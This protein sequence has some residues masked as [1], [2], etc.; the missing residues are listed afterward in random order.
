[1]VLRLKTRESRSLPGLLKAMSSQDEKTNLLTHETYGPWPNSKGRP[2][3][4]F[5]RLMAK[6]EQNV[7]KDHAQDLAGASLTGD[8][9]QW[10]L[11]RQKASQ[12]S[13][14]ATATFGKAECAWRGVEQP[15][16]SSGS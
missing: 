6:A 11:L 10:V 13:C 5:R 4:A 15:G 8:K 12:Q 1:M 7:C 3:A 16:S 9:T 2:Q 14:D